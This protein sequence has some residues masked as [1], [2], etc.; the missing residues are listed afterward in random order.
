MEALLLR[1]TVQGPLVL[2][3][4]PGPVSDPQTGSLAC[5]GCTWT[6]RREGAGP[7]LSTALP[8]TGSEQSSPSKP[9]ALAQARVMGLVW[10]KQ[11]NPEV[12]PCSLPTIPGSL[13]HTVY[14]VSIQISVFVF[15]SL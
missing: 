4:K 9:P 8:L 13:G 11:V 14:S 10:L 7:W 3:G 2:E 12:S 5:A 15:L 6:C 1:E